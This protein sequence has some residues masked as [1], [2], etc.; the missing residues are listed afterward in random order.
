[1]TSNEYFNAW[2]YYLIGTGLLTGCLWLVT[3]KLPW[4]EVRHLTRMVFVVIMV[5]PWYSYDNQ[6]YMAPAWLIA[7]LEGAFEGKDAFWR[8]GVPL[9]GAL[10]LVLLLA[11]CYYLWR[12]WKGNRSQEM[13]V[14]DAQESVREASSSSETDQPVSSHNTSLVN[15]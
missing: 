13:V 4:R 9:I 6:G 1:M 11:V 5:V 7:V 3:A 2:L 12:W 14:M 8:A 10:V 15:S